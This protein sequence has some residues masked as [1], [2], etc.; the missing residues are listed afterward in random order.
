VPTPQ[1]RRHLLA[2]LSLRPVRKEEETVL[3]ISSPESQIRPCRGRSP[4][5]VRPS[6]PFT[7]PVPCVTATPAV[8][9][10]HFA[11]D[12]PYSAPSH[13]HLESG[14]R[15]RGRDRSERLQDNSNRMSR[16]SGADSST[17]LADRRPRDYSDRQSAPAMSPAT[18][19]SSSRS[20]QCR[21][22]P[23]PLIS[24]LPA[25]KARP[26]KTM[27]PNHILT[28]G[29]ISVSMRSPFDVLLNGAETKEWWR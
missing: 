9:L 11:P 3:R 7:L 26:L 4:H 16:R 12:T 8:L 28:D 21:L 13:G 19:R 14:V 23:P 17:R 1:A 10:D 20:G 25:E 6:T 24:Y 18:E 15:N 27:V 2:H 29:N 22:S 5:P